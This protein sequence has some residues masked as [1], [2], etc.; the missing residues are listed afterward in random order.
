L[1]VAEG[2]VLAVEDRVGA[3][4]EIRRALRE[5]GPDVEEPF[6]G[7]THREHPMGRVAMVEARLKEDGNEPVRDEQRDYPHQQTF[8][9]VERS[10][11]NAD[12]TLGAAPRYRRRP[13]PS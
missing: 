13:C 9:P 12:V 11:F 2:M 1:G 5:P 8:V 3:R 10:T 6:H 4:R 7:F